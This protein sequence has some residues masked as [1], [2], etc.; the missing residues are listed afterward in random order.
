MVVSFRLYFKG[1]KTHAN[2]W[3]HKKNKINNFVKRNTHNNCCKRHVDKIYYVFAVFQ[4][5]SAQ[6]MLCHR[7]LDVDLI[8]IGYIQDLDWILTGATLDPAYIDWIMTG[9]WTHHEINPDAHGNAQSA[10]TLNI[11]IVNNLIES[12]FSFWN[13]GTRTF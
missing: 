3:K 7:A 6:I 13:F 5:R 4:T 8:L 12:V 2:I 9:A 1:W 10:V 11:F